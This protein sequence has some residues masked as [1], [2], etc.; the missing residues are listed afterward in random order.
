MS[1]IPCPGDLDNRDF[2]SLSSGGWSSEPKVPKDSG[3]NGSSSQMAA[4]MLCLHDEGRAQPALSVSPSRDLHPIMRVSLSWPMSSSL[5]PGGAPSPNTVMLGVK[6]VTEGLG[7]VIQSIAFN[8]STKYKQYHAVTVTAE[9]PLLSPDSE[10]HSQVD[11]PVFSWDESCSELCIL[12]IKG[13]TGTILTQSLCLP[14][15]E[16]AK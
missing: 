12:M 5:P 14:K 3:S 9:R 16:R 15:V 2:F 1:K 6:A 4:F 13:A 11:V 7:V 8:S 10:P